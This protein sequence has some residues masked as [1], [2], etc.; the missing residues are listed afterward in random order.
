[1]EEGKDFNGICTRECMQMVKIF[2]LEPRWV[3]WHSLSCCQVIGLWKSCRTSCGFSVRW[4]MLVLL[5][6]K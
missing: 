6:S 5:Y 2:A 3:Q 1:M 4:D